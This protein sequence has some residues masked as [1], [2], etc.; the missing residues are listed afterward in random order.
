MKPN[1]SLTVVEGDLISGGDVT[2]YTGPGCSHPSGNAID[3]Q[4]TG[5]TP[6]QHHMQVEELQ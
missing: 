6:I 1:Y 3:L 2:S 4:R 5:M